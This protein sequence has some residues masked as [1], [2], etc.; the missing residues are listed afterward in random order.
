M[1]E[2]ENS[3]T[4][5]AKYATRQRQRHT[6]GLSRGDDDTVRQPRAIGQYLIIFQL[7]RTPVKFI[8]VYINI[9]I[10]FFFLH[11]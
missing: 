2:N 4:A 10:F 3:S 7:V 5:G 8:Y 6:Y 9:V 1:I 11:D